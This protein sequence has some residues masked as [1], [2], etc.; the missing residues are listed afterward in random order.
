MKWIVFILA[1]VMIGCAVAPSNLSGWDGPVHQIE[2]VS[3]DDLF[4]RVAE[5][6]AVTL[7]SFKDAAQMIDRTAGIVV[8]HGRS[9]GIRHTMGL[10]QKQLCFT[11]VVHIKDGKYRV[12]FQNLQIYNWSD[13]ASDGPR[14]LNQVKNS[15]MA[16]PDETIRGMCAAWERDLALYVKKYKSDW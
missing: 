12:S 9:N 13:M 11:M 6:G 2:Q 4:T 10:W 16:I 7:G 3:Q 14:P 1:A 5:W 8:I 15:H